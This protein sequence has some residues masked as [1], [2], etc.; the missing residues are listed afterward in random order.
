M[1]DVVAVVYGFSR[2]NTLLKPKYDSRQWQDR[3]GK[4][5]YT[6]TDMTHSEEEWKTEEGGHKR[7]VEGGMCSDQRN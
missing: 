2:L 6:D 4:Q 7:G 5:G 3:A 1:A